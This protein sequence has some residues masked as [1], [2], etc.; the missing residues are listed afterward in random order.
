MHKTDL[1]KRSVTTFKV[2]PTYELTVDVRGLA[3]R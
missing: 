1:R 2:I 3:S